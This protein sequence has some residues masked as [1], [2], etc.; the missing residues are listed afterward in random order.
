MPFVSETRAFVAVVDDE[1]AVLKALGRLLR[2]AK[3]EVET[4]DS[5]AAFLASLSKRRPACVVLDLHMPAMSGFDLQARLAADPGSKVSVIA[6]TGH[7]TPGEQQRAM[8]AGAVLYLRKPVDARVLF[9][10]VG[11]AIGLTTP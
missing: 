10:A 5:G 7:D 6:I 3:F 8:A 9:S 11:S 4:F 2:S 1:P